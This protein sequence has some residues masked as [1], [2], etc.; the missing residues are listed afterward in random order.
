MQGFRSCGQFEMAP[1]RGELAML[2]GHRARPVVRNAVDEDRQLELSPILEELEEI[3][4]G[5]RQHTLRPRTAE[6]L[7]NTIGS[8][9]S[10]RP[11]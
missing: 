1:I 3:T 8:A 7:L 11:R 10:C 4:I 5:G 9:L 2:A 6:T